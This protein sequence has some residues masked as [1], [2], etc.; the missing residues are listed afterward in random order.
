[1][2]ADRLQQA[3]AKR[4]FVH[5]ARGIEPNVTLSIGVATQVPLQS[6]SSDD[7]LKQ[8]DQALYAAKSLG[9][10]RVEIADNGVAALSNVVRIFAR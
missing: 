3:L 1:M 4:P 5:G 6:L 9:R 2:V 10:N 8:A 7:L